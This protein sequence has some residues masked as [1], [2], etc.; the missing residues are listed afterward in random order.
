MKVVEGDNDEEEEPESEEVVKETQEEIKDDSERKKQKRESLDDTRS[1]MEASVLPLSPVHIQANP[2]EQ[3]EESARNAEGEVR[4]E[5]R[6][7][8][9]K[10]F[11]V[12]STKM[13]IFRGP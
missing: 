5:D 1:Q 11:N 7:K 9:W 2:K 12:R 6:R 4:V 13:G 10:N 3:K 8:A